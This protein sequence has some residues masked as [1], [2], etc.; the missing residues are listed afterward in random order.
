MVESSKDNARLAERLIS[1]GETLR[2]AG[3]PV[4]TNGAAAEVLEVWP[5]DAALN[6]E[7][8]NNF[9][10]LL[11]Q[12][13]VDKLEQRID[14]LETRPTLKYAGVWDEGKAYTVGEFVTHA[15]SM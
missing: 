1:I 4:T 14:A 2:D 8:L 12:H 7:D 15:G 9:L 13:V 11:K 3:K 10:H 5:R 6:G